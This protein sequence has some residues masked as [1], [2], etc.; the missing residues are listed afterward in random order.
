MIPKISLQL[1]EK[2]IFYKKEHNSLPIFASNRH[3]LQVVLAENSDGVV[4]GEVRF[5][6][7][8]IW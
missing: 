7:D 1:K 3:L 8:S 5:Y 6:I 2:M 4:A